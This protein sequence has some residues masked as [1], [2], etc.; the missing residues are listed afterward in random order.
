MSITRNLTLD[1][2][3]GSSRLNEGLVLYRGDKN[4]LIKF[5]IQENGYLLKNG[6]LAVENATAEISIKK[7]SGIQMRTNRVSISKDGT[8]EFL[9]DSTMCDELNEIG[10]HYLQ[11]HIYDSHTDLCRISFEPFSFEVRETLIPNDLMETTDIVDYASAGNSTI[12]V[13]LRDGELPVDTYVNIEEYEPY[14]WVKGDIISA[15]SL[16]RLELTMLSV[17]DTVEAIELL[18]GPKGEK[19]DRG[20]DGEPGLQGPKGEPFR[21][22]DFTEGQ[23]E[24]LRGPKGDKGDAFVYGDFTQEQ[25]EALK[26]PKGDKM[27]V[28]DLSPED[29]ELLRGPRGYQGEPFRYEDFTEGQLENLKGPQGVQGPKG[30]PFRYE[31]FTEG[32]L[33]RLRGPKGPKGEPFRY[34]DFTPTQ[35]KYLQGPQGIQGPQGVQGPKGIAGPKGPIGPQ[36]IQG[37]KG[38]I[39]P[40]G[41]RGER[42]PQGFRGPTGQSFR[43]IGSVTNSTLDTIEQSTMNEGEAYYNTDTGKLHAL[44]DGEI[45][46]IQLQGGIDVVE[47]EFPQLPTEDKTIIGAITEMYTQGFNIDQEY[48]ELETPS[49]T[50]IQAINDIWFY[51]KYVGGSGGSSD[52]PNEGY[53]M[54]DKVIINSASN[55]ISIGHQ[56][57]ISATV[58]P[59][60]ASCKD[61]KWEVIGN[62]YVED[63]VTKKYVNYSV[64]GNDLKVTGLAELKEGNNFAIKAISL[65]RFAEYPEAV[66]KPEIVDNIVYQVTLQPDQDDLVITEGAS[67]VI[68]ANVLPA[69]S[70]DKTLTW[71]VH[72]QSMASKLNMVISADTHTCTISPI[73]GDSE[74]EYIITATSNENP[75]VSDNYQ[76]AV[77]PILVESVEIIEVNEAGEPITIDKHYEKSTYWYKAVITPS[78][79]KYKSVNW[80]I[81][82]TSW[83]YAT[84]SEDTT[85]LKLDIQRL[86]L[87]LDSNPMSL[88]TTIRAITEGIGH[89]ENKGTDT[90]GLTFHPNV[91]ESMSINGNTNIINNEV[92]TFNVSIV[93][94]VNP[95]LINLKWYFEGNNGEFQEVVVSHDT[96]SCTV[97]PITEGNAKLWCESELFNVKTSTNVVS[98]HIEMES[99]DV[100]TDSIEITRKGPEGSGYSGEFI[101]SMSNI[102]PE[103]T[104][105]K[106][107]VVTHN[108]QGVSIVQNDVE[109]MQYKLVAT[110]PEVTGNITIT[111]KDGNV[112]RVIPVTI[113]PILIDTIEINGKSSFTRR[114][115]TNNYTAKFLPTYADK[116]DYTINTNSFELVGDVA[117]D[118]DKKEISFSLT[119]RQVGNDRISIK[120]IN[121]SVT[122]TMTISSVPLYTSIPTQSSISV[123]RRTPEG[124][125]LSINGFKKASSTDVPFDYSLEVTEGVQDIDYVVASDSSS[126]TLKADMI[127]KGYIIIKTN[128]GSNVTKRVA[129][130]FLPIYTSMED[131]AT[132]FDAI[133]ITRRTPVGMTISVTDARQASDTDIPLSITYEQTSGQEDVVY[134]LIHGWHGV[135]MKCNMIAKGNII[136]STTDGSNITKIIPY[137]FLPLYTSIELNDFT[138]KTYQEN[139]ISIKDFKQVSPTD[140]PFDWKLTGFSNGLEHV[141]FSANANSSEASIVSD[142]VGNM[143]FNI[144]SND[145]SGLSRDFSVD[146]ASLYSSGITTS[147][148]SISVIRR[149][150]EGMTLEVTNEIVNGTIPFSFELEVLDGVEDIE[151]AVTDNST[152]INLKADMVGK[153]NVI[154]KV[155][156]GS[157][158]SKTIPYEFLPLVTDIKTNYE[159]ITLY[160]NYFTDLVIT[161]G[162]SQIPNDEPFD[163]KLITESENNSI[164]IQFDNSSATIH[165]DN[166]QSCDKFYDVES[167]VIRIS[168]NDGSNKVKEIPYIAKEL[169]STNKEINLLNV[170]NAIE[171]GT[172]YTMRLDI[173]SSVILSNFK[174]NNRFVELKPIA[175]FNSGEDFTIDYSIMNDFTVEYIGKGEEIRFTLNSVNTD[176]MP[177]ARDLSHTAFSVFTYNR[178]GND[179]LDE[180]AYFNFEYYNF[181][182]TYNLEIVNADAYDNNPGEI[183]ISIPDNSP[184]WVD[185]QCMEVLR[186][187]SPFIYS[188]EIIDNKCLVCRFEN[189]ITI[190]EDFATDIT[191][192]YSK[193]SINF[194]DEN[195]VTISSL[196]NKPTLKY[197][198]SPVD[199]ETIGS[200]AYLPNIDGL[201][202]IRIHLK[203][204][205]IVNSMDTNVED[206]DFI[207]C[208]FVKI[209]EHIDFKKSRISD[210][211]YIDLPDY[212]TDLSSMFEECEY[213]YP[214]SHD[215]ETVLDTIVTDKI[216]NIQSMFRKTN[217]A[218][219]SQMNW[220]T[221]SVT[222]MSYLFYDSGNTRAFNLSEWDVSN[223]TDMSYMFAWSY[224]QEGN[225]SY[226]KVDLT[227]WSVPK[228][229]NVSAMFWNADGS[230]KVN[231]DWP[232]TEEETAYGFKGSFTIGK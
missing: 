224:V 94:D 213:L 166:S 1:V 108:I 20:E 226:Q 129:Y 7:P 207:C 86:P 102:Q 154:I 198:V 58:E 135:N 47:Q 134:E 32:Q 127:G 199:E 57:T 5:K 6:S 149:T 99:F 201:C 209:V 75:L 55:F 200:G 114:S 76:L 72:P 204:G 45:I 145:G 27:T 103:N 169:F 225:S 46:I 192:S 63:G 43:L 219:F 188:T 130:E 216:T 111:S 66:M 98:D 35:L 181:L 117:I 73:A 64:D 223:V 13:L 180:N 132:N 104:F 59:D 141:E 79:A 100:N 19:G 123:I 210:L 87:E 159:T 212:Y 158:I 11:F 23:L 18:P 3:P 122:N 84:L 78:N 101:I 232:F 126:I 51:V 185:I 182:A 42:G 179:Q 227:S 139:T 229:Q 171:V 125:T 176:A 193:G 214:N 25:L 71:S 187:E 80:N 56:S 143:T 30:E 17:I 148:D 137:E 194:I 49:K 70:L 147:S 191:I 175:F 37:P 153:G 39:G 113:K 69:T 163:V 168:T 146:I 8:V 151:T 116:F 157:N 24:R 81:P 205:T 107:F 92:T 215:Y 109:G 184:K 60:N 89:A 121:S 48:P 29:I 83:M 53:V 9:I 162:V 160:K 91:I 2:T 12:Q 40:I 61:V 77:K 152:K 174:D 195:I 22:E 140:I 150:P 222:N 189:D 156:D 50:I 138:L 16:N 88:S 228:L 82:Q 220:D 177:F 119:R 112:S 106:E 202:A 62:E 21:Y 10:K 97:T 155:N 68:K 124:M 221:S 110:K 90:L 34:E 26:G 217:V 15:N 218:V 164:S 197:T 165:V 173:P 36:G 95:D 170:P 178:E 128:D 93:G 208:N 41:P 133:A 230:V 33:E 85:M 96:L 211:I 136:I 44:L 196:G 74:G 231:K 190:T 118:R 203:D 183:R 161:N 38:D 142:Y 206:I 105:V 115:L 28:S 54:V 186:T 65:D 120:E 4:I 167:G 31:D 14:N 172:T 52:Q 144:S 131:I 67:K